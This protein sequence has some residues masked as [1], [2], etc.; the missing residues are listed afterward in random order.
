MKKKI[1]NCLLP[2][3]CLVTVSVSCGSSAQAAVLVVMGVKI[4]DILFWLH[5]APRLC[6][7][8]ACTAAVV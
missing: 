6:S 2:L 4:D 3:A 5:V 8:A 1:L 7:G